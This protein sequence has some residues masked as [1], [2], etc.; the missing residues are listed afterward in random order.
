MAW[1]SLV[2]KAVFVGAP[3]WRVSGLDQRLSEDLARAALDLADERRS[4]GRPVQPELWL[5]LGPHGAERASTSIELELAGGPPAGRCAAA[6]ALAR[7]GH[8]D[9]LQALREVLHSEQEDPQAAHDC[10]NE[11][12]I[13]G[14]P[15]FDIELRVDIGSR[16]ICG[17]YQDLA[18][19]CCSRTPFQSE[20]FAVKHSLRHILLAAKYFY[21]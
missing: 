16:L 10:E 11:L 13:I 8:I 4:A 9:R 17:A 18:F 19:L 3:L 14:F 5:C 1:R 6:L 15:K 7:A 20:E 21:R 2:V 12:P